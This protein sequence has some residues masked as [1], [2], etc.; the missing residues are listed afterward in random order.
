MFKRRTAPE[1]STGI[2]VMGSGVSKINCKGI[3]TVVKK[4][5]TAIRIHEERPHFFF[6]QD[7]ISCYEKKKK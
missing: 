7:M 3:R 5:R 4:E 2:A 1:G 6:R